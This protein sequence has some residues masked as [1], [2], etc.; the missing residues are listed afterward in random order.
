M[1]H[2]PAVQQGSPPYLCS[3]LQHLLQL[4]GLF[5][6]T[7]PPQTALQGSHL[8]HA[9]LGER[10]DLAGGSHALQL[11]LHMLWELLQQGT[12][13][14]LLWQAGCSS[15]VLTACALQALQARESASAPPD[16]SSGAGDR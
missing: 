3:S 10:R 16:S 7:L 2:F 4:A 9:Q 11:P 12:Q 6:A 8:L 14:L 13:T 1:A 15:S 5:H